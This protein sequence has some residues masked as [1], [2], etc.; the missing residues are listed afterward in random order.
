MVGAKLDL[1]LLIIPNFFIFCANVITKKS[2]CAPAHVSKNTVN[3]EIAVFASFGRKLSRPDT[4]LVSKSV[5]AASSL[6]F[7]TVLALF[8]I[9]GKYCWA[10]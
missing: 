3:T 2:I 1:K 8:I 6:S 10:V 4:G 7:G 5:C 9:S